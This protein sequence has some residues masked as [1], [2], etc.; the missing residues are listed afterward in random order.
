MNSK[1]Q[2]ILMTLVATAG[3]LGLAIWG[4]AA[5]KPF[6]RSRPASRWWLSVS[7]WVWRPSSVKVI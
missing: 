7:H 2:V 1:P 6:S 4:A 3:Y 5:L